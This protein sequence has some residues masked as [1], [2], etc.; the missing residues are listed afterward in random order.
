MDNIDLNLFKIFYVTANN[1]SL[2][3]TASDL[4]I[5]QPAISKSLRKLEES[6]NAKLYE[7][8]STGIVL[9]K[10]G[11]AVYDYAK[12]ICN[13]T[14]ASKELV[15]SIKSIQNQTLNVG[16]PTHIGTFY[17]LEYLKQF[18][19]KYPHVKIDII[20]KRSEEMVKMLECRQLDI[21][22]D[23]DMSS[24]SNPTIELI[25]IIDLES[26][27]VGNESFKDIASKKCLT[28]SELAAYPL[29]LP[30][31]TT[32]NRKLIDE[33]FKEKNIV[34]N[35]LIEANSSSIS[36]AIILQGIGIGWMIKEFVKD[37]IEQGILFEIKVDIDTVITP[38]S[39]AYH[40][41]YTNEVVKE[42]IKIFNQ[43]KI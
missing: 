36:R 1:G 28:A 29:I 25:K 20:N 7:R 3:K 10:E 40:K 37:E 22:I 31:S 23:T 12:Q 17:F 41:K 27:F 8:T 19:T 30:S 39:I 43:T 33:Y 2:T 16:V 38:V 34:L 21:L 11:Q 32:N 35:P 5:S 13:M 6:L 4:Y 42:F 14:I 18:N 24:I 9:T 26:C 15:N